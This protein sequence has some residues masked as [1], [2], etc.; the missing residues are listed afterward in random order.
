MSAAT[1]KRKRHKGR[2]AFSVLTINGRVRLRRVRWYCSQDGSE[3]PIDRLLDHVE[4]TISVGV[5][6]LTCLVNQ[7]ALS[8]QKAKEVLWST[9]HIEVSKE[10]V[11]QLV[12]EEGKAVLRSM[13]QA[14]I[15]PQWSSSDCTTDEG[16]TRVYLGC[17]GVKVPLVTEDEKTKRRKNIREKR[18][19]RGRKCQPLPRAKR[20]ADNAYKE[21][22]VGYL[23]DEHKAHRLVGVTAGNHEAAGRMLR[24]MANQIK[25]KQADE[26]V[27]LIDGAPWIR[28][29]IEYHGLT[30]N[31]GLDFWHL[32]DYAQKTRRVIYGEE[33]E[34]GRSWLGDLM[35]RFK[36]DGYDACWEQ[37]ISWQKPLRGVKRK[38]AKALLQYAAQR[39]DMIRYPEFRRNNWQI[40]SGPTEA[41]CKTTTHRVKGRGRRWDADNAEAVMA[42]AAL[43][44]SG[45]WKQHWANLDPQTN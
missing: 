13:R 32:Q 25:L 26:R 41:E 20:G 19:R 44:D 31:I 37:L 1:G 17:D 24:W 23:Y 22:K 3:V 5:R 16:V 40:G 6:E 39:Q 18:R 35:H 36:H 43:Q 4:S 12:E 42:L 14:R 27:A 8:F 9:A 2:Q 21:F 11:R 28:N 34:Q 10:T 33:S 30:A 29:Q 45:M 38:A 7:N 15:T